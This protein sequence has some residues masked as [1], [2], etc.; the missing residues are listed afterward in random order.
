M[1]QVEAILE[2]KGDRVITVAPTVTVSKAIESLEREGIGAVLVV[3]EPGDLVGILSERDVI[4]ALHRDGASAL[5][6]MVSDLMTRSLV[7]CD[8]HTDSESLMDRMV[9]EH[10]RH[11]PVIQD[12]ALSGV[13]SIGDV[14]K[15]VVTELKSMREIL[16]DHVIKSA[17]W[18]TEED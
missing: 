12:G 7:T 8:P 5:D 13:I 16:E 3:S 2:A 6:L 15:H 17:A 1:A 11:L 14:V 4:R 10:I 9:S 18:S